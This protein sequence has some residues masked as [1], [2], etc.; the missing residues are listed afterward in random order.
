MT[1]RPL[2]L[3]LIA[4]FYC[5]TALGFEPF[6]VRDIRV[7]GIQRTEAGTVFSYLPI[8]VGDKVTPER[9]SAAVKA[10]FATG[11]FKDVRLEADGDV[12]VVIVEER[13]AIAQIDVIGSKEFDKDKLKE[14]LKQIGLAESRIFDRALLDRAEQ[15]LKNQYIARGKYGVQITTTVTPLER[16]R[17]ALSFTISEGRVAKIRQIRF[18]GNEVFSDRTL[19]KQLT[20]R[21]PGLLTWYSKNDQYSKPKLQADLETLRS[22]YLNQGYLEFSIDSTQVSISPDK[23]DIFIT[24]NLTEGG[25]YRVADVKLA[26][27]LIV[28]EEELRR[29]VRLR[30]GEVFSRERLTETTKL[31]GDRLGNEG[32]AFAQVNAVPEINREKGEAS[33][34]LYVDPGRRIYVRRIN[35]SGNT[36]TRD[37]V[38][39]RELRQMESAWYSTEKLNRS[40]QRVDKLGFFSDVQIETPAV[41]GVADQVDVNIKVTERATGNLTLGVGYSTAEKVVLSAGI[42]QQNIFGTGNAL[43]LQINTGSINQTYALSYT[44]PYFTDDGVSRGFDVYRRDTDVSS[45][46]I[47]SYNT[48]TLGLGLRFGVPVTEYDTINY[49]LAYEQ[50]KIGILEDTPQRFVDFVNTFGETTDNYLGTAGWA[51]DQR[52]SIIYTTR[53][54]YQRLQAEVGLPG[55]DLTYYRLTY[56]HQWYYPLTQNLTLLLNGQIGYAEGYDDK[57]LPFFK[58]FYAGGVHSVRGYATATIGPKDSN[59]DA[60]GGKRQLIGNFELLFPFPGLEKDKSVRLSAFVDAGLAGEKYDTNELRYSTGLAFSWYS[61][62]GPLKLSFGRPINPKPDDKQERVQFTLGTLF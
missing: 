18:V 36:N 28:A 57:P 42:S 26:G 40:R 48:S 16:N 3:A 56:Q 58:N 27:E 23:Q 1:I 17:V 25:K 60:I 30:K 55:A 20:L 11:F 4:L 12:L 6:E 41:P 45:L 22:F 34:T 49:G 21:T 61:P 8:K 46:S 31:I 59:G 44:N 54:R 13:P 53:G 32:Y 47:S 52:D 35:I 51:R 37:E 24:I 2:P 43:S 9:A 7:E 5:S 50:T 29:L 15:E 62:V 14:A 38:I 10:L 39:R 33:F 19:R